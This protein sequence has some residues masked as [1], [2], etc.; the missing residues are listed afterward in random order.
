MTNANL[1]LLFVLLTFPFSAF[2]QHRTD[3]EKVEFMVDR[4]DQKTYQPMFEKHTQD[5]I[6][7]GEKSVGPLIEVLKDRD[8]DLNERMNAAYILGRMGPMAAKSIYSLA[9]VLKSKDADVDL[10]AIC[11]SAL[12]KIGKASDPAVPTLVRYL[13]HEDTWLAKNALRA[14]KS[15]KTRKARAALKS[16]KKR[17]AEEE[18][19]QQEE[20]AAAN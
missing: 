12:G 8:A 3:E 6:D 10:K 1:L 2:G 19:A 18:A 16:Y 15:I 11:A 17:K 7:I 4:L 9:F 20:E 14:L 13:D 5:L